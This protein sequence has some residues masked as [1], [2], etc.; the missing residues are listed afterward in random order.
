KEKRMFAPPPE[1]AAKAH[2]SSIEQYRE[3][4]AR[5]LEDPDEFW[6]GV[7]ADFH[8]FKKWDRVL[9]W[10]LPFAKWFVGAQ[11]NASYNLL[12]LQV[13]RGLGD[14][15]AILWEGEPTDEQGRPREVRRL[16]YSELLAEVCR[17]ANVLKQLGVQKRDRVTI[18]MPMIPELVIAMLA[19]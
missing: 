4:H 11:T 17:C 14:H 16:T 3:L 9:Q 7:A 2:V 19:C 1:F 15:T 13:Q 5:S 6:A 12:D 10:D 8:F 18:Y